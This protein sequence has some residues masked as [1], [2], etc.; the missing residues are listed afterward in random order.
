MRYLILMCFLSACVGPPPV[1]PNPVPI[2]NAFAGDWRG[3]LETWGESGMIS[4]DRRIITVAVAEDTAYVSGVC[5]AP[6]DAIA[7]TGE[8]NRASWRGL[9]TC[10]HPLPNCPTATLRLTEG[11]VT[12][13]D[14]SSINVDLLGSVDACGERLA[15][16]VLF[17]TA[18]HAR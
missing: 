15:V 14:D 11:T 7:F 13:Y 8:A 4:S 3:P 6:A 5:P 12:L 17:V 2:A 18:E 10:P 1:I 9:V 16:R